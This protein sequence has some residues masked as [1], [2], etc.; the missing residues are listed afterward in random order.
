M[1]EPTHPLSLESWLV[2]AGR[3]TTPGAPLN[4]PPIPASNFI[5]GGE[6][7]YARDAGTPTWDAR[8]NQRCGSPSGSNDTRGSAAC[9][10]ENVND[11]WGDLD[12]VLR[13]LDS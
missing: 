1:K 5:L 12:A 6:R 4:V 3:D 11:L 10:I 8:S 9:G 13:A 7:A 2:A